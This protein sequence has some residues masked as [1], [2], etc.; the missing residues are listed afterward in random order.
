MNDPFD[1]GDSPLDCSDIP[2]STASTYN[3]TDQEIYDL[4]KESKAGDMHSSFRLYQYYAFV[5]LDIEEGKKWLQRSADQGHQI[6]KDN[7][8]KNK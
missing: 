8:K 6:A 2:R 3:L 7:I 5:E 1:T 4:A